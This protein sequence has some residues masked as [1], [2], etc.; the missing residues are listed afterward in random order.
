MRQLALH[1]GYHPSSLHGLLCRDEER[2]A[3]REE[4]EVSERAGDRRA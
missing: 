4:T 2:R 3:K 1:L